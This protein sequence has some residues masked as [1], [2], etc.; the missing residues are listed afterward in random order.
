MS[1][2]AIIAIVIIVIILNK[3]G[4]S[5]SLTALVLATAA[6]LLAGGGVT[7]TASVVLTLFVDVPVGIFV[8]IYVFVE[9]VRL[10]SGKE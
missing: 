10:I 4:V 6:A 2:T 1:V 9:M 7:G 8:R 5:D 3:T